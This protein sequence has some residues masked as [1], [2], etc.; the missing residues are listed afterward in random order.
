MRE[1]NRRDTLSR[2]QMIT[3]TAGVLSV[4]GLLEA[5]GG[6][7]PKPSGGTTTADASGR[8]K[9]G[10][11][12]RFGSQGASSTDSPEAQNPIVNPDFARLFQMYTPLVAVDQNFRLQYGLAEEITPNA[13]ASEWTFRLR[14]NVEF[15]NGKTVS[16]DDVL[17]SFKRIIAKKFSG[18]FLLEPL[19]LGN[20]KVMDKR[21][22]RI[23]TK[24]P[25][26]TLV[27]A[28][29]SSPYFTVVPIGY[30][31]KNPVGTGPF[32]HVS[33]TPGQQSVVTR[34]ANYWETG[35]PY[36]DEIITTEYSSEDAQINALQSGAIDI[37]DYLSGASVNT[38]KQANETVVIQPSGG[39]C[40][41]TLRVDQAPFSDVRVR[42]AVKYLM[43]RELMNRVVY[44]GLGKVGNDIFGL[45][46][47]LSDTS[48]PQR[49]H[50][51]ERAK[52]LLKAAGQQGVSVTL[53]TAPIA[54]GAVALA[55]VLA[56]NAS[57]AGMNVK[58]QQVSLP[59]WVSN[60]LKWTFSQDFSYAG[61]YLGNVPLLTAKDAPFNE[62]KFADPKYNQLYNAA[63]ATTDVG[64]QKQIVAEMQHIDYDQGGLLI[65][66]FS[67]I[68]DA[69]NGKVRGLLPGTN[70]T[71]AISNY[72]WQNLWLA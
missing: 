4:A 62:T 22:L 35:K 63:L 34:F 40:S 23:P 6:S 33:F 17:F 10:G 59:N 48:I 67:P 44:A 53:V 56:Q 32:K 41:V 64:K 8:P 11:T 43:D 58:L 31:P 28:I 18:A 12:L 3:A 47:P 14:P 15:H 46:D 19:D 70:M 21:T 52:S 36:L 42:Q 50:D 65:P 72:S 20:A 49:P 2:R 69:N 37:T 7:T 68:I 24:T 61:Y 5:C 39:Y 60:Y 16:A 45:G 71:W 54:Q 13:N 29:A 55:Q 57:A 27:Q 26:S 51:P 1:D 9:R 38:L 66:V 25:Y 30:D